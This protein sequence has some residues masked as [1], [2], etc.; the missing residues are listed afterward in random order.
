YL[1]LP[2]GRVRIRSQLPDGTTGI[3]TLAFGGNGSLDRLSRNRSLEFGNTTSWFT[4]DSRHRLKLSAELRYDQYMQDE[5]ADQLGRFNYNS[6]A[7]LEAA[8]PA[9]FSRRL[10]PR[11]RE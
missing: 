6:L 11:L 5:T 10:T 1:S 3:S 7:D 4:L 2:E 8:L 9:S